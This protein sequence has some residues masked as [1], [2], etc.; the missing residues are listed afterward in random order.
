MTDFHIAQL[1][2]ARSVAPLDDAR[3]A[4]FMNSLDEI[5][6]LGES[7]PGFVWRLKSDSGNAT[8]IKLSD[9]P[10]FI[11]NLTV[12]RSIDDLYA[13]VYRSHHK[14]Y[15]AR[16]FEWF[17]R[18]GAPSSVM[19]WIPAGT[20]PTPEEAMRRLALL[21]ENGPTPDAFTFKQ[22]FDPHVAGTVAA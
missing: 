1:N 19:W 18:Y 21:T 20:V 15:F 11:I 12:W 13:F 3:M 9:N 7:S 8:D 16:R 10:L 14:D 5:N 17:E 4:D 6:G 22:R 2:V